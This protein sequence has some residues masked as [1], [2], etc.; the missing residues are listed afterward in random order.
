MHAVIV[1]KIQTK[2]HQLLNKFLISF[3][4]LMDCVV[5]THLAYWEVTFCKSYVRYAENLARNVLGGNSIKHVTQQTAVCHTPHKP[6]D[7]DAC[8]TGQ[9]DLKHTNC[10]NSAATKKL[11]LPIFV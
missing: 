3:S 6:S 10:Q 9:L 1:A 5:F 11:L 8:I 4:F 2:Q 7:W